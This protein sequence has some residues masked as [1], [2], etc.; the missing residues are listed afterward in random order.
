MRNWY[1]VDAAGQVL[2]RLATR[3]ATMLMGKH[4]ATY[5]P[6][7]DIG[8]Y[9]IVVNASKIRVTGRKVRQKIYFR[10]SG[11]PGGLKERTFE[12]QMARD[13]RQVIRLAVKNMLPKNAL[14]RK[15]L[16]KLKVYAREDH[17]HEAQCPKPLEIGRAWPVMPAPR[18]SPSPPSATPRMA[19]PQAGAQEEKA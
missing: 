10:H 2:G 9:V 15:R 13:S 19:E 5:V 6:N 18:M 12:E 11:Y 4:K 17:P 16:G 8:D 14:G 3:L 1:V 7:V